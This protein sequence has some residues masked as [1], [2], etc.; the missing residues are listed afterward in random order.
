MWAVINDIDRYSVVDLMNVSVSWG[1]AARPTMEWCAWE[2]L[3][4]LARIYSVGVFTYPFKAALQGD[5][6]N[7]ILYLFPV[8][9]QALEMEWD[10]SCVPTK[11]YTN[12]DYEA[13]PDP[14]RGAVKFAAA[15]YVYLASQ[16]F[17]SAELMGNAFN[18]HLGI[19]RAATDRGGVPSFYQG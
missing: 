6:T 11:L 15:E 1:S 2:E 12:D 14:Y 4:A 16:R 13:I 19:D 18:N 8:P 17:A 3:Q 10:C 7:Q 9:G 5:G